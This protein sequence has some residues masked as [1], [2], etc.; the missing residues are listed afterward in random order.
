MVSL[1]KSLSYFILLIKF[2]DLSS[3]K[4]EPRDPGGHCLNDVVFYWNFKEKRYGSSVL[5]KMTSLMN[6]SLCL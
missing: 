2:Q 3:G 5:V 1:R 6:D 4:S